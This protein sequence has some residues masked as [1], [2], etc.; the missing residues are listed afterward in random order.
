MAIRAKAALVIISVATMLGAGGCT[1]NPDPT[2]LNVH[3]SIRNDLAVPVR[4]SNCKAWDTKCSK[5][6]GEIGVVQ[7]GGVVHGVYAQIGVPSPVLARSLEGRRLG[8]LAVDFKVASDVPSE[9]P[10][11][12]LRHC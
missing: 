1:F 3:V 9:V 4:L 7:P 11:T 6:I 2:E 8:C 10:L 12:A 5:T